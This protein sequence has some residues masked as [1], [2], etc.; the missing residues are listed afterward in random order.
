MSN[1]NNNT[2]E[3]KPVEVNSLQAVVAKC[4]QD[5]NELM[6]T[7]AVQNSRLESVL[8]SMNQ[9][10]NRLATS[11]QDYDETKKIL[12]TNKKV[13][14]ESLDKIQKARDEAVATMNKNIAQGDQKIIQQ[15]QKSSRE[16]AREG[17]SH[18]TGGKTPDQFT[19][20]EAQKAFQSNKGQEP[21]AAAATTS[22]TNQQNQVNKQ[23]QTQGK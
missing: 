2:E 20:E 7:A 11:K 14:A 9:E 4:D 23:N 18:F 16:A 8:N 3:E 19:E 17:I 6:N 22:T 10:M 21:A 15:I 5:K 1:N 13:L 12:D